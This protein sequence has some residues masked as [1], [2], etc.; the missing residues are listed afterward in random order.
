LKKSLLEIWFSS[1]LL[2]EMRDVNKLSVVCRQCP[3]FNDCVGGAR[4]VSYAYFNQLHAPDP[5]CWRLF[6][7]LPGQEWSQKGG[8]LK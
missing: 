6:K 2:Q 1:E 4:C 8:Y 5:Q 7:Y 3:Y